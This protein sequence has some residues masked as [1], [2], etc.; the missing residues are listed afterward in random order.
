M[1]L[2]KVKRENQ[3]ERA[4][5]TDTFVMIIGSLLQDEPCTKSKESKMGT[6]EE[7]K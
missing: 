1:L 6:T 4:S 5:K 3:I 7:K 2:S